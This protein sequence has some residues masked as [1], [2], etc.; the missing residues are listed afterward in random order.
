MEI[1]N[2]TLHTRCFYEDYLI[3]FHPR[4]I[5]LHIPIKTCVHETNCPFYPKQKR[6]ILNDTCIN[7]TVIPEL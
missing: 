1:L 4:L 7:Y 2:K 3:P 5:N 6:Q